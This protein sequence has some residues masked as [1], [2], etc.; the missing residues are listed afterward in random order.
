MHCRLKRYMTVAFIILAFSAAHIRA[1]DTLADALQRGLLAEEGRQDYDAA[2][3]A[4]QEALKQFDEDRKLAATAVFRLGEC[5]RKQGKT[6]E[7]NAQFERVT[8]EFADQ[9]SLVELSHKYLAQA[10]QAAVTAGVL[11]SAQASAEEVKLLRDEMALVDQLIEEAKKKVAVGAAAPEE[12]IKVQRQL[13]P[14]QRKL[15]DNAS[16]AKQQALIQEETGLVEKLLAS[17]QRQIENG[18]ASTSDQIQLRRE[19]LGLQRELLA[20][21]QTPGFQTRLNTIVKRAGDTPEAQ[22]SRSSFQERLNTI[23]KQAGSGEAAM[24]D[25]A[26]EI[27]RIQK[28]IQNSPD[29]VND[30]VNGVTLLQNAAVKGWLDVSRFLLD[31]GADINATSQLFGQGNE[32][33]TAL[34]FA[35]ESGHKTMVELLLDRGAA[36]D[37]R[38]KFGRTALHFAVSKGYLSVAK[39]LIAKDA[40]VNARNT[41]SG[42]TPLHTAADSG[43]KPMAELLLANKAEINA[44]D[45]SGLTP[46]MVAV[47][48]KRAEMVELLLK[49]GADIQ[50]KTKDGNTVLTLAVQRAP[51][52]TELLLEKGSEPNV[53]ANMSLPGQ[54]QTYPAPAQA[55]YLAA[56][57]HLAAVGNNAALIGLLVKHGAKV[58]LQDS[59]GRTALALTIPSSVNAFS[60]LLKAGASPNIVDAQGNSPLLLAAA[61]DQKG[62]IEA[63]LQNGA[64][65][66]LSLTEDGRF[67]LL[68][69]VKDGRKELVELLLE[70]GADVNKK[71]PS[72]YTPLHVAC[73]LKGSVAMAQLLLE[74]RAEVNARD[75]DG[76]TPLHFAVLAGAKD[77]VK[78]LL[79][80][81]ADATIV[82][83][84]NETPRTMLGPGT[85]ITRQFGWNDWGLPYEIGRALQSGVFS[86]GQREAVRLLDGAPA[87]KDEAAK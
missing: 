74:R 41:Q 32:D 13:L 3:R 35:A 12:V 78:L 85:G 39:S 82:N 86:A 34:Q 49:R 37:A 57:I 43:S 68:A 33:R 14:L 17:V 16:P 25:E 71:G 69:A 48:A 72:G 63:L 24:S 46:L 79:E 44:L 58:D 62:E 61:L 80:H 87:R 5:Y 23:V 45:N 81:G 47:V 15:P 28:I 66:N 6:A 36:V 7:A 52:F 42:W 19:M 56:P 2:V 53:L 83:S 51:Q 65:P 10:R 4:Y 29:L 77:N 30:R 27:Q 67:P 11:G 9:T 60:E 84:L 64:D 50:L 59:L 21:S 75:A 26:K 40:D 73:G 55:R 20:V 22:S 70:K 76:N 18:K 8:R 54:T 1:A 38:D 31:N